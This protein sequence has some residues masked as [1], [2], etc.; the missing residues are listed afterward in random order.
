MTI[1]PTTAQNIGPDETPKA[2]T[3]A[4]LTEQGPVTPSSPVTSVATVTVPRNSLIFVSVVAAVALLGGGFAAGAASSGSGP[5]PTAAAAPTVTVTAKP[6]KQSAPAV[7][8]TPTK[9]PA[10]AGAG[11]GTAVKVGSAILS[12]NS[13]ETVDHI[14]VISGDTFVPDSGG[15]L[16]LF[17]T[18]YMNTQNV[19]DLSC[20][21]TDLYIQVFDEKNREMAP[22]FET[23]RIPGNQGCNDQLLQGTTSDWNWAVQGVA[24]AT[25]TRMEVTNSITFGKPIVIRLQ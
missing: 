1:D 5:A 17:R 4:A 22:V 2:I 21:S 11:I 25:P 16:V 10:Q 8:P 23:Y 14:D 15:E 13:L 7:A 3:D 12:V 6:V 24:G 19:A 18:S 9:T 20:G